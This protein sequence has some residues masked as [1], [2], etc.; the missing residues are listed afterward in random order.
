MTVRERMCHM[1]LPSMFETLIDPSAIYSQGESKTVSGCGS[2]VDRRDRATRCGHSTVSPGLLIFFPHRT[3]RWLRF[4]PDSSDCRS[5]LWVSDRRIQR[6][7]LRRSAL[8]VSLMAFI[9]FTGTGFLV[10]EI[11]RSRQLVVEH[12]RSC[13]GSSRAVRWPS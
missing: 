11:L 5:R 8:L 13:V 9:G 7:S 2:A 4:P 6:L 1:S 10:S 12:E 3:D